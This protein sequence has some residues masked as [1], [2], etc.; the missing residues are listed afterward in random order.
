MI[1]AVSSPDRGGRRWVLLPADPQLKQ[2]Q[3]HR[4]EMVRFRRKKKA[5]EAELR[6]EHRSL[7]RQMARHL[8]EWRLAAASGA[9]NS[10][11][12]NDQ[13]PCEAVRELVTQREALRRDNTA[14]REQLSRHDKMQRVMESERLVD[15]SEA[16]AANPSGWRVRFPNGEPSFHFHPFLD[17][18]CQAIVQHYDVLFQNVDGLDNVGNLLGWRVERAPLTRH[19]N[20]RAMVTRVRFSKRIHC[21]SGASDATMDTLD[22]QSWP[23]LTTPELW[24]RVHRASL[25][26]LKLQEL[27]E[28]TCVLV[29]NTPRRERHVRFLTLM[30]RRRT[31]RDDGRR[32]IAY[33]MVVADSPA[34]QRS[35]EAEQSQREVQWLQEGGALMTLAQLDDSTLEAVYDSTCSCLNELQARHLL[36]EWGHETLRWEQLVTPSRL[37]AM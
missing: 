37:L 28:D 27:D 12:C 33:A 10:S 6:R 22:A 20:G 16:A 18:E 3:H 7:E 25:T 11:E 31:Q 14:L 15:T 23:V 8:A 34:N 13:A 29:S 19:A 4:E 2:R 36:V 24:Q 5:S 26:C 9:G 17:T 32:V 30:H 21:A 1:A 35:R